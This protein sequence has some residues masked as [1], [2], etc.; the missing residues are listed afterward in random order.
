[1]ESDSEGKIR[2]HTT[3]SSIST[4]DEETT[5]RRLKKALKLVSI[6]KEKYKFERDVSTELARRNEELR[7]ELEVANRRNSVL[8][9]A[10]EDLDEITFTCIDSDMLPESQTLRERQREIQDR[11]GDL[12]SNTGSDGAVGGTKKKK[13]KSRRS[14]NEICLI[15]PEDEG[16]SLTRRMS[17]DFTNRR[18]DVS[19]SSSITSSDYGDYE[20]SQFRDID[21]PVAKAATYVSTNSSS[22]GQQDLNSSNSSISSNTITRG[23]LLSNSIE[24]GAS[25]SSS[26]SSSSVI[27]DMI[28]STI[29]T[30]RNTAVSVDSEDSGNTKSPLSSSAASSPERNTT[31]A[32]LFEHFLIVGVPDDFAEEQARKLFMDMLDESGR[33]DGKNHTKNEGNLKRRGSDFLRR[34]GVGLGM[35]SS[36]TTAATMTGTA[37]DKDSNT[38]IDANVGEIEE[39]VDRASMSTPSHSSISSSS[40]QHSQNTP[41]RMTSALS[42]L[43]STRKDHNHPGK[44]N[45]NSNFGSDSASAS[46]S[47]SNGN[48]NSNSKSMSNSNSDSN[49]FVH[50]GSTTTE[51]AEPAERES[52][53]SSASNYSSTNGLSITSSPSLPKSINKKSRPSTCS[54]GSTATITDPRLLYRYPEDIDPPPPEL[55]FFCLPAG[56]MLRSIAQESVEE[57]VS[58]IMYGQ[59]QSKRSGRCFVFML[60]DKSIQHDDSMTEREMEERGLGN[61]KLYGVCVIHSR[62]MSKK[63]H[64]ASSSSSSTNVN[65][66]YNDESHNEHMDNI[67][68][69]GDGSPTIHF[70]ADVCYAFITRYPL[71]EFLFQILFD[72]LSVERVARMEMVATLSANDPHCDRHNYEYIPSEMLRSILS[73][74]STYSAPKFDERIMAQIS[75]H[76]AAREWI[77]GM[78]PSSDY[79]ERHINFAAWSLPVVF[80]W[81]PVEIIVWALS[82]LMCEAKLLVVGSEAGIVTSTILGLM[83]ML[84]PLKWVAPFI[85]LL[86]IKHIDFIESPVPIVAGIVIRTSAN[87]IMGSHG[88]YQV[89]SATMTAIRTVDKSQRTES[90][91]DITNLLNIDPVD[92]LSRVGDAAFGSICAV[93][94]LT[95]RDIFVENGSCEKVSSLAIPGAVNL[96]EK[97]KISLGFMNSSFIPNPTGAQR[98]SWGVGSKYDKPNYNFSPLQRDKAMATQAVVEV[99]E[100]YLFFSSLFLF[101]FVLFCFVLFCFVLFCF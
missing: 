84:H 44:A 43:F 50:I 33:G 49:D 99:K 96:V 71:F 86:P 16:F 46:A 83:T 25:S 17:M 20:I 66:N 48:S 10:F 81:L 93:L 5:Q 56:A 87:G 70:E 85:P 92:L 36:S 78:P 94:D 9:A 14:N 97:M 76:I 30:T 15:L 61:D 40:A 65:N 82:L 4:T 18:E 77:R 88:D 12:R 69:N 68:E 59:S 13:K 73:I 91:E 51:D 8:L 35:V 47:A 101:C 38:N 90:G 58:E 41:Y 80:E 52:P 60:E 74:F 89:S 55:K 45:I 6:V 23:R 54:I 19:R 67:E 63:G 27:A 95:R 75:H 100:I 2:T 57:T 34:V 28:N 37:I 53:S 29:S 39:D 21:M 31:S 24:E 22:G 1:M 72:I 79:E 64:G 7:M 11:V 42:R 32:P 26:T 62:L 98:A 3:R